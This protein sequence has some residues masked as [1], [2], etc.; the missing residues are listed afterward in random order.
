[1]TDPMS[2]PGTVEY[3]TA[4]AMSLFTQARSERE[5]SEARQVSIIEA[6]THATLAV[7]CGQRMAAEAITEALYRLWQSP[8]P[9]KHWWSRG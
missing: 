9:R 8:Q 6:Q 7:A 5:G 4:A 1:M 2:S 3:H